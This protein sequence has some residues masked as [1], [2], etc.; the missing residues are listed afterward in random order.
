MIDL[1]K[2]TTDARREVA[3]SIGTNAG[4]RSARLHGRQAWNPDDL[5]AAVRAR[6]ELLGETE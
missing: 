6:N 1:S 4:N 5:R 2:L 3:Q